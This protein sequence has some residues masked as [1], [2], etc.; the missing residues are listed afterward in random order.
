[1]K[2]FSVIVTAHNDSET[3]V[4]AL[5]SVDNAVSFFKTTQDAHGEVQAEIVVVD[6]GSRDDTYE[7][8]QRFTDG[9][10]DYQIIRREQSSSPSCARNTGA[11]MS[12]ADVL[13]F[14][15]ADDLFLENHIAACVAAMEE[16]NV[17]FVKTGVLTSDPVHPEW[18]TRI[19]N[20]IVINLCV[21]RD[22]HMQIGGFPDYHLFRREGEQF[23]PEMDLFFKVEDI[24]YNQTLTHCFVGQ[25]LGIDSVKYCRHP[26]NSFDQQYDSFLRPGEHSGEADEEK[27]FRFKMAQQI[28]NWKLKQRQRSSPPDGFTADW[29][30]HNIPVWEQLLGEYKNQPEIV[31]LEIGSFEGRATRWLLENVLTHPT[32]KIVCVDTFE[33]SD[34]HAAMN[35]TGLYDRFCSN[36]RPFARRVK[37]YKETSLQ[38]LAKFQQAQ[39]RFDFIYIDGSHRAI[40][41]LTDA[42]LSF[43]LLKKGGILLFDDYE[44]PIGESRQEKPTLAIDAFLQIYQPQFDLLHKGYQVA[45]RK[46]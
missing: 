9:K 12:S 31:F 5:Q 27:R 33:G 15:D 41:V 2:S 10:S 26:G 16:P 29:F 23:V 28:V 46:K 11:S 14:L 39:T 35:L 36:I 37:T 3:I 45:V 21:R 30:S 19:E 24:F 38:A 25:K 44:Y 6:D 4:A 34:E 8:L 22:C 7:R 1:M 42:T 32:S 18:K 43:P 20:S 13:F 40:D 17:G